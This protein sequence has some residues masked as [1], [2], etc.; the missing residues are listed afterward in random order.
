MFGFQFLQIKPEKVLRRLKDFELFC[1]GE[2]H[3][4]PEHF[5]T[6]NEELSMSAVMHI[7]TRHYRKE[8]DGKH[9]IWKGLDSREHDLGC[10]DSLK[11]RNTGPGFQRASTNALAGQNVA[12]TDVIELPR[13][14]QH[15]TL[16]IMKDGTS[17]VGPDYKTALRNAAL[18]MH[19]KGTF[20]KSDRQ[21]IWDTYY[22]KLC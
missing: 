7:G 3:M 22:G 17:S 11:I 19:L 20:K 13:S 12:K 4:T 15:V 10:V 6:L 2:K 21:D 16:V 5:Q 14:K 18:K 1:M 9:L 8:M